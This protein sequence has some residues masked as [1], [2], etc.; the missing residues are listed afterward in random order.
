MAP[1][2]P[3]D[4]KW[5]PLESNPEVINAMLSKL[6][7]DPTF[8]FSDV[9]GLDDELLSMVV[10]PVKAIV[11]LF[12][13]TPKY[14]AERKEEIASSS[15]RVSP[16]VW[17]MRQ[18]IGNACGTM[19]VI[20]SLANNQGDIQ[21]G[22]YL[23]KF[24]SRVAD[25]TPEQRAEV[26]EGD[27]V[28]AGAHLESASAGQTA[29]PQPEEDVELHFISFVS[30]DGD[31]YELDG[32]QPAPFNHGPSTDLL[33]DAARVIKKRIQSFEGGTQEFTVL[34]LGLHPN[35]Q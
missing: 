2:T 11:F 23:G 6:G 9:W 31:L 8:G 7:V 17:F 34:S 18:T 4:I 10:Q 19:A 14:E 26:L 29:A 25:M 22:G 13:L 28:I 21:V 15:H 1:T 30:V 24:L 12:P 33:K 32:R 5:I 3:G 35:L 16:S 20:H 27:A